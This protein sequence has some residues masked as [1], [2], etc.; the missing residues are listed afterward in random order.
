M[1]GKVKETIYVFAGDG[2]VLLLASSKLKTVP[3][4]CLSSAGPTQLY[5]LPKAKFGLK[6]RISKKSVSYEPMNIFYKICCPQNMY[7]NFDAQ[8]RH[9]SSEKPYKLLF[10][11]FWGLILCTSCS[12]Q[13]KKKDSS[14]LKLWHQ[15]KFPCFVVRNW[16]L[17]FW[18]CFRS[19]IMFFCL[20]SVSCY[21]FS[22][23]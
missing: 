15:Q 6:L 13:L 21:N 22:F 20:V 23:G 17:V 5:M 9:W 4:L 3:F 11:R 18:V 14:F 12:W 7:R 1:I 16:C 8:D 2:Y 19:W 10:L